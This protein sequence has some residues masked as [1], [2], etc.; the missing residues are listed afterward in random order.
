M[1]DTVPFFWKITAAVIGAMIAAMAAALFITTKTGSA[2]QAPPGLTAGV[3]ALDRLP[4]EA[5]VPADVLDT[6][7][8]FDPDVVGP[9]NEAK[10][11]LRKLRSGGRGAD[12]DIYAFRSQTQSV[13]V[14][15]RNYS[16]LC[17]SSLRSGPSGV[18]FSIGGGYGTAETPPV[19]AGVAADHV[20]DVDLWVDE[21]EVPVSIETNSLFAELPLGARSVRIVI[22]Y[23]GFDDQEYSLHLRG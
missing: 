11:K 20:T 6:L 15:V 23:D 9:F 19:F 2:G 21:V 13:C 10:G 18:L 22:H 14:I 4:A 12:V 3:S 16:G 7:R 5:N 17:P 8:Y 1:R